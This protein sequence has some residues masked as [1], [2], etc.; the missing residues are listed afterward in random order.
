MNPGLLGVGIC[1]G[2]GEDWLGICGQESGKGDE[3]EKGRD[4]TEGGRRGR[5]GERNVSLKRE[6]R[7]ICKM[8]IWLQVQSRR[9]R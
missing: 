4:E 2:F 6:S 8:P 7:I 5:G 1:L 3:W 9:K